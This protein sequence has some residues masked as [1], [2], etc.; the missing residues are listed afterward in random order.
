M[1]KMSKH[2][3]ILAVLLL[4]HPRILAN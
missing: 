2:P 4:K 3:R 1:K